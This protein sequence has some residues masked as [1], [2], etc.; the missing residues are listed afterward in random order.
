MGAAWAHLHRIGAKW[1]KAFTIEMYDH[2]VN[3]LEVPP[4]QVAEILRAHARRHLDRALVHRAAIENGWQ[5]HAVEETYYNGIDWEQIRLIL[6]GRSVGAHMNAKEK[7]ALQVVVSGGLWPEER[8]WRKGIR[9]SKQCEAC[10]APA[11]TP[12]HPLH[13]CDA[14]VWKQTEWR[15]MSEVE[16]EP[17][18]LDQVAF[19]PLADMA[20]PPVKRAWRP[21]E[22]IMQEGG[23]P[24]AAER[25]YGDGSGYLQE[26]RAYRVAT[27]SVVTMRA[28]GGDE[29]QTLHAVSGAVN[30]WMQTVPRA[31]L[32]SFIHFARHT[33]PDGTFVSDCKY[34][35]NRVKDGIPM[36]CGASSDINADLWREARR[37]QQ[38]HGAR[39]NIVKI[40]SHRTEG[41]V[42]QSAESWMDILDWAGNQAADEH[43]KRMARSLVQGDGRAHERSS[44]LRTC[45]QLILRAAKGAA[46]AFESWPQTDGGRRAGDTR[47]RRSR[48]E[49]AEDEKH[50]LRRCH[51]GGLECQLCRRTARS[52]KGD[53]TPT[54]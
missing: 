17:N 13:R 1:I 41:S 6:R 18:E 51:D 46:W 36:E 11:A 5:Q 23:I 3:V 29:P 42:R 45:H 9:D 32:S 43:A 40:K 54:K 14:M 47:G 12:K 24:F 25:S 49:P 20:L 19:A 34:V 48:P 8:R 26:D 27:W 4:L 7:R 21:V 15:A 10:G 22:L 2:P 31:E 33:G 28:D 44:H 30:G 35:V 39:F 50:L 38:D 53:E 52:A 37:V 16:R